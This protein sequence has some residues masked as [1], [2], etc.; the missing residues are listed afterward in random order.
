MRIRSFSKYLSLLFFLSVI[1][2]VWG[3]EVRPAYL[4]ITQSDSFQYD[5]TWKVPMLNGRIPNI[6]P[7][8]SP[9]ITLEERFNRKSADAATIGYRLTTSLN[10]QGRTIEIINLEKTLIDVILRI[11]FLDGAAHTILLQPDQPKAL[12][13]ITASKYTVLKTFVM[14]GVEHIL[15]GWDHL[16]F[17]FGLLL[18]IDGKSRLFWTISAFTVAH[19]LTLA[20]STLGHF[21]LPAA[22]VE[23]TIAL[24]VIFL[25]REYLYKLNG[26]TTLTMRWPWMVALIFG[27]L[28]GFG[29]AGALQ[30]IGL[31]SHAIPLSLFT[32]NLGV[33]L[34]QL[35]FVAIIL[36]VGMG[37]RF[38]PHNLLDRFSFVPGYVIGCVASFWF[39]SRMIDIIQ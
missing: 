29:F 19:S 33:E 1:T 12:I 38:I 28:H 10:L 34:G 5:I 21:S 8:L 17:V 6:Y 13:P 15:M 27:L 3:H 24:S 30:S 14:L 7:Q 18:L 26:M 23:A 20:L 16:L 31:P 25:G 39:I 2:N 32:F 9:S 22:P 4:E 36:F 37:K 11:D 35:I